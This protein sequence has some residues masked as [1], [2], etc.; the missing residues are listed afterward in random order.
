MVI[1]SSFLTLEELIFIDFDLLR[2]FFFSFTITE[3]T[4]FYKQD[5]VAQKILINSSNNKLA[6]LHFFPSESS[7]PRSGPQ[8]SLSSER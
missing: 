5:L 2:E 3:G 1:F 7:I 4:Y 8:S 6:M